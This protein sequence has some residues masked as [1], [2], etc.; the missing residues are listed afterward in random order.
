MSIESKLAAL[1]PA[2]ALGI[3]L[4]FAGIYYL[5]ADKGEE[6]LTQIATVR[7]QIETLQTEVKKNEEALADFEKFKKNL[8]FKNKKYIEALQVLT[9]DLSA[10]QVHKTITETIEATGAKGGLVQPKDVIPKT[11]FLEVHPYT[12]EF[13]GSFHQIAQFLSDLTKLKLVAHIEDLKLESVSSSQNSLVKYSSQILFFKY[14]PS[15]VI[16]GAGSSK[17]KTE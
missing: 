9:D 11:S 12:V 6:S 14:L 15:K 8:E 2:K 3:G 13:E 5:A 4:V 7:S 17:G 10:P 16:D 1:S